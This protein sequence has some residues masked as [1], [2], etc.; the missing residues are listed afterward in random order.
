MKLKNNILNIDVDR[1]YKFWISYFSPSNF[2]YWR[3]LGSMALICLLLQSVSFRSK[4]VLNLIQTTFR[5]NDIYDYTKVT[6]L[7]SSK[8]QNFIN[9]MIYEN[10]IYS[11]F[12]MWTK[13]N[14]VVNPFYKF[15]IF[16]KRNYSA[17]SYVNDIIFNE[18]QD[19]VKDNSIGKSGKY[20]KP[21]RFDTKEHAT[22]VITCNL[23]STEKKNEIIKVEEPINEHK[24]EEETF[25]EILVE[26]YINEKVI[27]IAG[28]TG[29]KKDVNGQEA[30]ALY[31]NNEKDFIFYYKDNNGKIQRMIIYNMYTAN[32]NTKKHLIDLLEKSKDF[33][34]NVMNVNKDELSNGVALCVEKV[35]P[36]H[37]Q[38][39][40]YETVSDF[41]KRIQNN[42]EN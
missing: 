30:I 11:E 16:N 41:T 15:K 17:F 29:G 6:K 32:Q 23:E 36:V 24:M 4:D 39:I 33:N 5:I 20:T 31:K 19:K 18:F 13:F 7:I 42:D 12:A 10:S 37:V 14:K 40:K 25:I 35:L 27:I 38:G 3:N 22:V 9:L 8:A 21:L 26:T 34:F 2:S 1:L 28:L